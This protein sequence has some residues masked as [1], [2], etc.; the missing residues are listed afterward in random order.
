MRYVALRRVALPL[1][2]PLPLPLP[3]AHV[4]SVVWCGVVYG[5]HVRQ[6]TPPRLRK[7]IQQDQTDTTRRKRENGK[8]LTEHNRSVG[9]GVELGWVR[10]G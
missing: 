10:L 1:L 4:C 6:K 2:L 3:F 7:N 8:Q 5:M 9:R